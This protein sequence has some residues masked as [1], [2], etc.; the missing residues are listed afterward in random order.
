MAKIAYGE[1]TIINVEEPFSVILSNEAQSIPTDANRKVTKDFICYTDIKVT[2]GMTPHTDFTIGNISSANGITV[3]KSSA[4]ITFTVKA[5]TTISADTGTFNIPITLGEDTVTKVFSWCC[6]KEGAAAKSVKVIAESTVFKSTDGGETFSPDTIRIT[7][8]FQGGITFSKWQY[9]IDSGTTWKDITNG[10]NGLTISSSTLIVSKTCDLYTDA[11]TVI[12]FKC[13]SN[14]SA[15]YDITT[16]SKLGDSISKIRQI[17]STVDDLAGEIKSKVEETTIFEVTDE[18]GK[19][20]KTLKDILSSSTQDLYGFKR[21]VKQQYDDL[22]IGGVNLFV[23]NTAIEGKYLSSE[24]VEINDVAWG[25]SDYINVGDMDYYI[26]SG[27]TNLGNAPATCFYN[28]DKIFLSGVKSELANSKESKRKMLQ[29]PYGAVYMRFSFLLADAKTL[30]IEKGIKSTSYSPSPDDVAHN[31]K[32]VEEQTKDMFSW[33]VESGSSETSL[34][35]TN[36]LIEAI[37]GKFVVK[38]PN[39]KSVVIENGA[40]NAESITTNMLSANSITAEKIMADALK[41]RNYVTGESGS[42]LNLADGSFDSKYLKWDNAGKVIA[43]DI[44]VAGGSIN[45]NDKFIVNND[46]IATLQGATVVGNITA[47]SGKIGKFNLDNLALVTGDT[48]A[49]CAGLGGSSQA[50][51]AGSLTM[52]D[53]PFRVGYDGKLYASDADISGVINSTDGSIGGWKINS[54]GIKS[55]Y[56]HTDTVDTGILDFS[57]SLSL[58]SDTSSIILNYDGKTYSDSSRKNILERQVDS[59]SLNE[60]LIQGSSKYTIYGEENEEQSYSF[61]L[62]AIN[63]LQMWDNIS[64]DNTVYSWNG[65]LFNDGSRL[66]SAKCHAGLVAHY[67]NSNNT[68]CGTKKGNYVKLTSFSNGTEGKLSELYYKK[69]NY[70]IAISINGVYS[71]QTRLAINS[72]TAN[73]RVEVALF[74]NGSRYAAYSASYATPVDYT[75]GQLNNYIL[76]LSEGDTIDFRIASIDS[77]SVNVN[78]ADILIYALDYDFDG[79]EL[80]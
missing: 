35:I 62:S 48:D 78:M 71:F 7:P 16:I 18:N 45:V 75:L 21:E 32:T 14:N 76:Y 68:S 38:S 47:E 17:E 46:G 25:Y 30:K 67:W 22:E 3:T 1:C 79:T 29:I 44:T 6:Q 20:K 66:N 36:G 34:K 60:C 59:L 80:L 28:A 33:L 65:I 70:Q 4:R 69:S 41:S 27:F 2:Q 10:K 40:I 57:N 61:Y 26:A 12:S 77:Y 73:K 11:I 39:G 54:E 52:D 43:N 49:T 56:S 42:F 13:L 5:G 53:A 63:G 51:W 37:T 8:T 24:N 23:Q 55:F 9:S 50:F 74:K 19:V 31:I 58:L 64:G 72:P 15:Y